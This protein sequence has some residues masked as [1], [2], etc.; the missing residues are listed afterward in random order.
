MVFIVL[1]AGRQV[2][3]YGARPA[4]IA[5][6]T[7]SCPRPHTGKSTTMLSQPDKHLP[8][9]ISV[10]PAPEVWEGRIPEAIETSAGNVID[11]PPITV[12]RLD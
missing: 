8:A 12:R 10:P 4:M 9:Y 2:D 7:A 1:F 5:G 6:A 11:G 3:R